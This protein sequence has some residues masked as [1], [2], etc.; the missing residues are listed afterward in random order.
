MDYK[1]FLSIAFCT[2][3]SDFN[4]CV[5]LLGF[6][7]IGRN[8]ITP[9]ILA[10]GRLVTFIYF[11]CFRCEFG[12]FKH[13]NTHIKEDTTYSQPDGCAFQAIVEGN[14]NCEV[15]VSCLFVAVVAAVLNDIIEIAIE[16][17][18]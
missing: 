18:I 4:L 1:P 9:K 10:R 3:A 17:S 6:F 7:A 15:C 2:H 8:S 12:T 5:Y 14:N 16:V 13:S 11:N